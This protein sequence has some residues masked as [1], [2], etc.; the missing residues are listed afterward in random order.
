M[1]YKEE[2]RDFNK[3]IDKISYEHDQAMNSLQ[4]LENFVEKYQPLRI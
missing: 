1:L 2:I 4:Q 3:I